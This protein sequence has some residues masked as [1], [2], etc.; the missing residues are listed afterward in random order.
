[1]VNAS[2]QCPNRRVRN[3]YPSTELNT[4]MSQI[5]ITNGGKHTASQW[6][7]TTA[8]MLVDASALEGDRAIAAERLKLD[9]AEALESHHANNQLTE[10]AQIAMDAAYINTPYPVIEAANQALCDVI[11]V[12]DTTECADH[13]RRTELRN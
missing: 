10:Q 3:L 9:V 1:M 7:I 8:A 12:T 4:V 2:S 11:A 5:M 13:F 6:A